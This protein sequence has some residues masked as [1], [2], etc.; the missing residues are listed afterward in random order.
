MQYLHS[1]RLPDGETEFMQLAKGDYRGQMTCYENQYP[2]G[3]FPKR[4]LERVEFAPIT[5]FAGGNGSGKS[6]ILN[7]LAEKLRLGRDAPFNTTPFFEE[8]I[9]LCRV[10]DGDHAPVP[11]ASRI[12]TSDDVFQSILANRRASEARDAEREALLR[13]Y[14]E[15]RG[16]RENGA[17]YRL[18]SL[19]YADKLKKSNLTRGTPSKYVRE[20]LSRPTQEASNGECALDFFAGA[21]GENALYLLDEPEN[22]L[23]PLYQTQLV[24]FLT[25]SVRFYGCQLVIATHSPILL[26]LRGARIYDM[27][28]RPVSPC[29]WT[30]LENVRLL[31]AFFR[32]HDED[33]DS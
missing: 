30:E 2:F 1:L 29:R 28:A 27:D 17:G 15:E 32:E 25:D 10:D 20:F 6:T 18:T 9:R 21:I 8:Y 12:I 16:R 22:S 13:E 7:V 24:Q 5:I 4:E 19:D 31:H 26:A 23:S 14:W 33:F 3:I 11:R